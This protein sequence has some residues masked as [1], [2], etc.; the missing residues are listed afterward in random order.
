MTI[1]WDVDT[2]DWKGLTASQMCT[3]VMDNVKNGSI[4]LMHNNSDNIIDG[5]KLILER[6]TLQ[7]YEIT[8]VG[9]LI[10]QDNYEIDR[11]GVQ[12]NLGQ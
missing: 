10:Y 5:L 3:R 2:L 6:L 4:I 9:E 7:G 1:Q 8:S 11:N 12:H